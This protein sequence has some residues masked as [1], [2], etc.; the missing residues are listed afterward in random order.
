MA[1]WAA[2]YSCAKAPGQGSIWILNIQWSRQCLKYTGWMGLPS[3]HRGSTVHYLLKLSISFLSHSPCLR[4]P[5]ILSLRLPLSHSRSLCVHLSFYLPP[6]VCLHLSL[7]ISHSLSGLFFISPF[8]LSVL[9]GSLSVLVSAFISLLCVACAHDLSLWLFYCLCF[10]PCCVHWDF[11]TVSAWYF[12]LCFY[13]CL[14]AFAT[15]HQW[16]FLSHFWSSQ[17]AYSLS[18][19][20]IH[21]T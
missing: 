10:S 3:D 20:L 18:P 8:C 15:A 4:H 17:A 7:W 1:V 21:N 12:S 14:S 6:S 13:I 5:D 19:T 11:A 16:L 9:S 2:L